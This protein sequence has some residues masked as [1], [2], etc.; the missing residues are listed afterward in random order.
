MMKRASG[1]GQT[2]GAMRIGTWRAD[3]R[4]PLRMLVWKVDRSDNRKNKKAAA[5]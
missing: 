5:I 3:T 4:Y 2:S 1:G